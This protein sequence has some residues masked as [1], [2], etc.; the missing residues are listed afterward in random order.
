MKKVN[1]TGMTLEKMT[2]LMNSLG[3]PT[4]RANQL[5]TWLYKKR[6]DDFD[7][8]TVFSKALRQ[9]LKN[10]SEL[11]YLEIANRRVSS[12]GNTIKFLFK[13][14]D[15][16]FIESVYMVDGKRRTICLS[17]QVGCALGCR[18]CATGAMGFQRNL[19]VG[20]IVDQ[21][22]TIL[23]TINVNASNLV[24]MGIGGPFFDYDNVIES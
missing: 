15:G 5:F 19:T 16:Q 7:K 17:S 14:N 21:L 22:L 13:L 11:G 4:Y 9:N 24:F 8:I 18:F 23:K 3:Q 6:I 2:E 12:D 1:I 10:Y 20:E